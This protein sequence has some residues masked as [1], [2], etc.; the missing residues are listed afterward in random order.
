MTGVLNAM[1]STRGNP[2]GDVA[3]NKGY[4]RFCQKFRRLRGIGRHQRLDAVP[5]HERHIG[6]TGVLAMRRQ[7][8]GHCRDAGVDRLRELGGDQ[9]CKARLHPPHP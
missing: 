3:T 1:S 6:I 4:L 5:Q 2:A 7:S 8:R 9:I